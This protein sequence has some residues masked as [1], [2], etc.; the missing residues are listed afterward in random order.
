MPMGDL[1]LTSELSI[2][3]ESGAGFLLLQVQNSLSNGQNAFFL[4]KGFIFFF[5]HKVRIDKRL[6]LF[7]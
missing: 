3:E 6:G 2:S 7:N 5:N 1:M 4:I